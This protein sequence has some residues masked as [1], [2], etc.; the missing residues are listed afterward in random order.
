LEAV[1]YLKENGNVIHQDIKPEN[2][3]VKFKEDPQI[4]PGNISI[5][6]TDF[7]LAHCNGMSHTHAD[8]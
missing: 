2:I 5:K 6:I 7:G 1:F 3:L 8:E 4:C